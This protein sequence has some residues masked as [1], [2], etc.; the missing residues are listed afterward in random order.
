MEEGWTVLC[1]RKKIIGEENER[2]T[3]KL[4]Q[5]DAQDKGALGS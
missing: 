5:K 2:K 4:P 3:E 1:L